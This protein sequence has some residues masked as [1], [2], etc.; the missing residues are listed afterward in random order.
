MYSEKP[1]AEA[2]IGAVKPTKKL[3]QPPKNPSNGW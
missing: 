1:I 3:I 2:A